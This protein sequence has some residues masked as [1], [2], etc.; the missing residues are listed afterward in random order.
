[1]ASSSVMNN[2]IHLFVYLI[3]YYFSL[4]SKEVFVLVYIKQNDKNIDPHVGAMCFIN[5][6]TNR[7]MARR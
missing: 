6:T 2:S 4:T 5:Y 3:K 7:G 1:M